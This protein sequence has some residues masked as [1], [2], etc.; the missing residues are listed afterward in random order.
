LG[1]ILFANTRVSEIA[2]ALV[3]RYGVPLSFIEASSLARVTVALPSCTLRQLLDKIVTSAP[4]YRYGF[5]GP[6]LVL[7]STEPR[8]QT[9]I[10]HVHLPAGARLSVSSDLVTFLNSQ[11]PAL[12]RLRPPPYF[13]IGIGD[14]DPPIYADPVQIDGPATVMELFTQ[15]L[16]QRTSV[17]FTVDVRGTAGALGLDTAKLVDSLRVTPPKKV[18]MQSGESVQLRVTG[19]IGDRTLQDLTWGS[20]GTRYVAANARIRVSRDGLVTAISP[21]TAAVVVRFDSNAKAIHFQ[22]APPG[23]PRASGQN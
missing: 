16:G 20:C 12:P 17:V 21:G 4:S 23:A 7:Y 22:V 8:W 19:L 10:E 6:H 15:L 5:V 11:V 14:R 9:R 2:R 13:V 3:H 1:R 18:L